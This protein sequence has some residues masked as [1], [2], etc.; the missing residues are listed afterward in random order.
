ME[1]EMRVKLQ[2]CVDLYTHWH[3]P[4]GQVIAGAKENLAENP[5][6]QELAEGLGPWASV[7][8]F[9]SFD[10]FST[11]SSFLYFLFTFPVSFSI[12]GLFLFIF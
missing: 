6:P 1:N 11:L 2:D 9:F 8:S 10:S 7:E 3:I 5:K 12:F 4:R